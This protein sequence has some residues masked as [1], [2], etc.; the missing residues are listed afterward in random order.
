MAAEARLRI[1]IAGC[2]SLVQQ[3][4]LPI[5]KRIDRVEVVAV[6]DPSGNAC[7]WAKA[8]FP[9]LLAFNSLPQLLD[10]VSCDAVIVA[11]PTGFHAKDAALVLSRKKALYLEKPM[12]S[13][14]SE[15]AELMELSRASGTVAMMG[16][17][18][19]YN[20]LWQHVVR[21]AK[22]RPLTGLDSVFCLATRELPV[23]KK[24]RA[25]G[26]GALLDLATHHLD[27]I[28]NVFGLTPSSIE[29][30]IR[31]EQTEHDSVRIKMVSS[32]GI[33]ITGRYALL[34]EEADEFTVKTAAGSRR[35]SRYDPFSY[36]V[37]PPG[38]FV[39]Y[40]A[41]RWKSPWKE[42]SFARSLQAWIHAIDHD[43]ASPIPLSDGLRVMQLV[44]RAESSAP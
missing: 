14:L 10:A 13:T 31:S 26:G 1:A 25:S 7:N 17:N 33:P 27:L 15:A 44:D 18:Y 32:T 28:L 34:G 3:V 20:F 30:E 6:A 23:W 24:K 11:S 38:K 37:F 12:A 4:H 2:G 5:L 22:R 29:A 40:H 39:Q 35:F 9:R 41:A 43:E 8:Q 16:F 19:R 36:P 21:E 42:A